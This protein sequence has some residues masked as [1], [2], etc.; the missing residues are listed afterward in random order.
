MNRMIA[1]VAKQEVCE[2]RRNKIRTSHRKSS[3][4]LYPPRITRVLELQRLSRACPIGFGPPEVENPEISSVMATQ[5]S[6]CDRD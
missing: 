6:I 1:L 2:V 5:V 3:T 4:N